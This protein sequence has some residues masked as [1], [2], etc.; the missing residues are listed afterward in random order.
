[1]DYK[2][3]PS[4]IVGQFTLDSLTGQFRRSV[5]IFPVADVEDMML[6]GVV[7]KVYGDTED[8]VRSLAEHICN[9]HNAAW[10]AETATMQATVAAVLESDEDRGNATG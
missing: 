2:W 8:G 1:M 4:R 5:E 7:M 9:W 10:Q 3:Q 6:E